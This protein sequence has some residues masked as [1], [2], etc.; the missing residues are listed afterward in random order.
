MKIKKLITTIAIGVGL[1]AP[2]FGMSQSETTEAASINSLAKENDY[3]G[4][5]YLYK[6]LQTEGIKYNKFYADGNKIKYRYGKPEGIVIHE[7]ATPN[8]T[9]YN[10]AI[11]FNR[12]WMKMYAYVHAF[13]DHKQVIQMMTPKYG[14]WGAGAVANNRFFQIELAEENTRDN[15]AKSVNNDAIYAAKILHRYDLTPSNAVNSGKGTIWSHHAVSKYLGGTNHTDPDGYFSKWGYSMSKFYSLIK[16][17]YNLQGAD[18]DVSATDTD[19]STT[20]GT[21]ADTATTVSQAPT[22]KQTLMHDAYTYNG[23]GECTNAALKTAGTKV[24]VGNSK[25]INGKKYLQIGTDEYVVASNIIGKTRKLSHNAYV[26]DTAGKRTNGVKLH[27]GS[28]VRTYGGKVVINGMIYY[29]INT[30]EFVKAT[31][32]N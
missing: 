3:V 30:T 16:Y 15:F 4:V 21:T 27:R 2:V 6:L 19:T 7:T 1:V 12:E 22:G 13:V 11:Y 14:V 18:T 8:A 20:D 29:Q 31:N 17:Y 32:F 23:Q 26:Y 28:R 9:A 10:E 5:T 25:T 24:T